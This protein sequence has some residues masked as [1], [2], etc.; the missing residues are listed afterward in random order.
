MNRQPV[1]S[2]FIKSIGHEEDTLEVEMASGTVYQ[3]GGVTPDDYAS[4]MGAKSIGKH[5]ATN[6]RGKFDHSIAEPEKTEA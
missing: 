6:V 3:F 2:S 4:L 5:F 1:K